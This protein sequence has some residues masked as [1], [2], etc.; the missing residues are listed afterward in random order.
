M[1]PFFLYPKLSTCSRRAM[2]RVK[3][4]N[5]MPYY[6]RPR[7]PLLHRLARETGWPI[8]SVYTRLMQERETLLRLL[9]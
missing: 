2:A 7:G 8:E 1:T 4:R 5:G 3:R 9:R 6:Y